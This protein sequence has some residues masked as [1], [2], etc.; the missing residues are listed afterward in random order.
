MLAPLNLWCCV[1][2]C[3]L[4]PLLLAVCF[5]SGRSLAEDT[6]PNFVVL[7][8]DDLGWGDLTCYG[9]PTIQ[10]PHLDRMAAEGTRLTQF[11]VASSVCTPSRA[12][13]MTGCYPQRIGMA[14]NRRVLFPDSVG[15]IQDDLLTIPEVLKPMGYATGMVGK[16]HLG[17]HPHYLPTEH[18]FDSYFGIPYSNDMDNVAPQEVRKNRGHFNDPK[19]EYFNV[20]LLSGTKAAGV[21]QLERPANQNT[22]TKRYTEKAVEF[23]RSEKE[24]PFFLYLAHSLPHVP[25]F[26]HESFTGHSRAGLYGDVIEEIDWSVGQVLGTLRELELDKKTMVVF[27]SDNGPWLVFGDQ[28]GSAGPLRNGKGTT[29]E[30]GMRVPGIFWM[31]GTIPA[32]VT[33]A[34]LGSTLDLLPTIAAMAGAK[35]PTGHVLD[36]YDLS[37]MLIENQPSP[38]ESMFFYRDLRLMAVR[39]G[40]YKAHFIT[41][42]SYVKGSNVATPHDPPL[43]YDLETDIG[44][45]RNIAARRA[46]VVAKIAKVTAEHQAGMK[47]A[48]SQLDRKE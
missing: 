1:M 41:Q 28:G 19:I 20:P 36:G 16:W 15:G 29:F 26:R 23:I 46:D 17:H 38:R 42:D 9:H 48:E 25:L 14:G 43:V 30:G 34:E 37:A 21:G 39:H 4:F 40:R 33:K 7:F 18:G 13:L 35:L 32:G 22:I 11:Y 45:K 47:F 27:S 10:T 8:C 3:R 5:L 44:E 12:A 2:L 6:Q 31:P 24:K